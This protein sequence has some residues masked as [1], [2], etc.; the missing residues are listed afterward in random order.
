MGREVKR[1]PLDF[2]APLE[3]VWQGYLMPDELTLPQCPECGGQG[4]SPRARELMAYWYGK[5]PFRP[6]YN[7]STPLTPQTPAVRAFAER[8]VSH[9]PGFYGNTEADIVREATRLA[10]LWNG[11]WSHHLNADDVAAL[12]EEGRLWSLTK[13][14]TKA[15]G[16]QPKDP[17]VMPTP[18]QV[19]EWSISGGFGHD[20]IN[21]WIVIKARCTREGVPDTCS[22]CGGNG[23]VGTE[24][25][26]AAHEAWTA[27]EP[28]EGEGWQLWETVSEG[29]PISPVFDS[30]EGLAHW[31]TRNN[32]TVSG[33][34]PDLESALR[35]VRAG[36]APTIFG[37][38]ATGVIDGTQWVG[39]QESGDDAG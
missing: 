19:N 34:M 2:D 3:E 18:K 21:A 1:V 7:G 11:Q 6:G 26:R 24:Q 29:S 33:P 31:M 16:W 25:Q 38:A 27:T 28:P 5:I 9:A 15:D 12:V 13:T 30:P 37:S 17:P 10:D 22:R 14:W 23:E 20:A 32:C 35:F 36:W 8:N 4:D 39:S